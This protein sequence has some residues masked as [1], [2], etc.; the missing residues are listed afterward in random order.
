MGGGTPAGAAEAA[1]R[2]LAGGVGGLLSFGLAGGL[3]PALQPGTLVIPGTILTATRTW[4][5]NADLTA[6]FGGATG[7]VLLGDGA[8]LATQA[9]KADAFRRTGAHAVD[10]ES[11][12][13]AEAAVRRGVPFAAVRAICDPA[14]RD[15][16]PAALLALDRRGAI[17]FGRV[18]GSVLR[19]PAQVPALL[20]LAR[21]AALAR[22]VLL[23]ACERAA[24]S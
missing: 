10:L 19:H 20:A 17:G 23:R 24:A 4:T 13:V 12:A 16:P 7:H 3:D 1:A 14:E 5:A 6:R 9:A 22:K 21:D 18:L 11:G 8:I 15:L 2:L